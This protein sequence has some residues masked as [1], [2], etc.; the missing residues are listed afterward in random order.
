MSETRSN[1]NLKIF[2]IGIFVLALD[3]ITK[4]LIQRFLVFGEERVIFDGFFRLVHWGNT[5]AAW[6]MFKDNNT[7]L[8]I[9]AVVA[10]IALF[11]NRHH[12]EVHRP[13]GQVAMGLMMGGIIGNLI[14]RFRMNHVIDFLYFYTYQRGGGEIGFPAFNVADSAI[15][16]GVGLLLILSWHREN[17]DTKAAI[18]ES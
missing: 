12:F 2:S 16:T 11:L 8:T 17:E 9:V 1:P 15:C 5:G 14:D 3:Q 13:L 7:V 18:Q 6:S 4:V 10:V